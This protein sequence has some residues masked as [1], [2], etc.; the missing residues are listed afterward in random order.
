MKMI[1]KIHHQK[2]MCQ[3]QR[4]NPNYPVQNPCTNFTI[5][6][7]TS[8]PWPN[9]LVSIITRMCIQTITMIT[10]PVIIVMDVSLINWLAH[11][12]VADGRI[13]TILLHLS[14]ITA[15]RPCPPSARDAGEN[16]PKNLCFEARVVNALKC[17]IPFA[18]VVKDLRQ[19]SIEFQAISPTKFYIFNK[20]I[21]RFPPGKFPLC[22]IIRSFS[23]WLY[24]PFPVLTFR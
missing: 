9:T 17:V 19:I 15:C 10:S 12:E 6:P 1:N 2:I 7:G 22:L 18:W 21:P 13:L 23:Q 4:Q 5:G 20:K 3:V 16:G 8:G 11:P 14:P 24:A